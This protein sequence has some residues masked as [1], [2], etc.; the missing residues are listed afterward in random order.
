[1]PDEPEPH[2]LLAL[3]LIHDAR[4]DARFG[5]DGE[6]VL[7]ADQDRGRWHDG[8]IED[9]RTQLTRALALRGRGAYVL[10]AAIASAQCEPVLDWPR[11]AAL[12]GE[13]SALTGSAVVE[14][15]RAVAVAHAEGPEAGLRD[16][17]RARPGDVSLPALDARRPVAPARAL[18]G[19]VRRV[20]ACAG[21]HDR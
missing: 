15:N 19:G 1:M 21:A 6:L 10:Q 7:L 14:L 12:Y 13:L 5:D 3:M 8:E 2:G 16:R 4:R 20:C 9:G 11:I 17:R 18:R